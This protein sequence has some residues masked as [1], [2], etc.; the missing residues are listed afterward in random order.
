MANYTT[1]REPR[2][3]DPQTGFFAPLPMP[4][5]VLSSGRTVDVRGID[6]HQLAALVGCSVSNVSLVL[7]GRHKPRL[8]MAQR[9]ASALNLSMDELTELLVWIRKRSSL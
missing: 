6:R 5:I 2:S 9:F 4:A 7:S 8:D 3:H 1:G